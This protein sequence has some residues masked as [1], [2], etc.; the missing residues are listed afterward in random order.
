[1][2]PGLRE[3]RTAHLRPWP[4]ECTRGKGT[5]DARRGV[6]RIADR[7]H[8]GLDEAA[9]GLERTHD[10]IG[11]GTLSLLRDWFQ[12]QA[13]VN[14]TVDES[15]QN[16]EPRGVDS[17]GLARSP[18][19]GSPSRDGY[20]TV[21]IGDEHAIGDFVPRPTVEQPRSNEDGGTNGREHETSGISIGSD[22][23]SRSAQSRGLGSAT[24]RPCGAT[25][26]AC[27]CR[28]NRIAWLLHS[29]SPVAHVPT[30]SPDASS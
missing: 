26:M 17:V 28:P 2:P 9:A 10:Q 1:M 24:R 7:G 25:V 4:R 11:S 20:T 12:A 13:Q 19:G 6:A 30:D 8:T 5:L 27:G 14:V 21:L 29:A 16:R 3:R 15:R 23:M 22:L 18:A